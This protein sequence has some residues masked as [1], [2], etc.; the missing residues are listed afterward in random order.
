MSDTTELVDKFGMELFKRLDVIAEKLGIAATEIWKFSLKA[1]VAQLKGGLREAIIWTI[2]P[3]IFLCASL[4]IYRTPL[5][6]EIETKTVSRS[7]SS[8]SLCL[9]SSNGVALW[10]DCA[11]GAPKVTPQ[12]VTPE[13][14]IEDK[15]LTT[16]GWLKAILGVLLG[17]IGLLWLV[18]NLVSI[19]DVFIGL[20]SIEKQ[21][22]DGLLA[23]LK[24]GE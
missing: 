18:A 20:A 10:G 23:Q 5:S 14:I 7:V 15:G 9:Q 11:T 1:R 6:H 2:V 13:K 21:T 19:S 4:H 16:E 12:E 22:F 8:S 17:V 3:V 24:G